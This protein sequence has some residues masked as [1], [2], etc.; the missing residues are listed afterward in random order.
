MFGNRYGWCRAAK[1]AI[2][3]A[4]TIRPQHRDALSLLDQSLT[5][6]SEKQGTRDFVIALCEALAIFG[7]LP[8]GLFDQTLGVYLRGCLNET[9][10][11]CNKEGI[12][13]ILTAD[14]LDF[15]DPKPGKQ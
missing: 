13:V 5:Q 9:I 15:Y 12:R 11:D 10:A 8:E 1:T 6:A 3:V 2:I 7:R 14:G 4:E